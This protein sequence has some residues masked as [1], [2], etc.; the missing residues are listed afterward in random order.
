[1]G[2]GG[3]LDVVLGVP[4]GVEDYDD[5]GAG[6]VDAD[7]AGFGGEEEDLAL[8]LGVVV[9]VDRVLALFGFY[10]AVDF[11]VFYAFAF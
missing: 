10:L 1:M 8:F 5:V 9:A 2:S 6:E 7:A 3:G 11:L 4:V